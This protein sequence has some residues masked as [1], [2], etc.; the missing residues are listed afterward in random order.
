MNKVGMP[1]REGKEEEGM[2]KIWEMTKVNSGTGN[3]TLGS[4]DQVDLSGHESAKC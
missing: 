4:A 1:P 2:A 3:R